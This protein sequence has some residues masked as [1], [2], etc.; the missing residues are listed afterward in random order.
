[1][2]YTPEGK[3][4]VGLHAMN[5]WQRFLRSNQKEGLYAGGHSL[6]WHGKILEVHTNSYVGASP[7]NQRIL[8]LFLNTFV[9]FH[10]SEEAGVYVGVDA[11][12]DQQ[13]IGSNK[14][15][16]WQTYGTI[17]YFQYHKKLRQAFRAEYLT[18]P[19]ILTQYLLMPATDGATKVS[20][21]VDFLGVQQA[22]LRGEV[23]YLHLSDPAFL[24]KDKR[25]SYDLQITFSLVGYF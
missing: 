20:A 9:H 13:S 25:Y 23:K 15:N 24:S 22:I 3:W 6:S 17:F 5:G 21:S 19:N 18:D 10:L 7:R 4:R 12:G 8:R 1:L 11:G 14:W 16:S 2:L